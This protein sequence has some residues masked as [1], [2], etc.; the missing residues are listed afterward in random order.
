MLS[1]KEKVAYGLGDAASNIVFQTVML[2]LAVYYT[3][4]VGL[5]AGVVGT[6]FLGVRIFDAVTDPIMGMVADRTTTRWGKFRPFL[7][8]LAVPYGAAT[9]LAFTSFDLSPD[10]KA[11][12][13]AGT[14][15][16]LMTVYT[17]I[18]IPYS[19]LGGVMTADPRERVTVQ[20]YRFAMAWAGGLLVAVLMVPLCEQLGEGNAAR[21]YQRSMLA[22]SVIAA[23]MFLLCFAGTRE[24]VKPEESSGK[25]VFDDLKAL[26]DNDQLLVL[27]VTQVV[28]LIGIASRGTSTVYFANHTLGLNGQAAQVTAFVTTGM[29]GNVV[30]GL[31]S[32]YIEKRI[33]KVVAA[34]VCQLLAAACAIGSL[35]VRPEHVTMH[36]VLHF[37]WAVCIATTV[38]MV[39]AM[40]TDTIDYGVKRTHRRMTGLTFAIN[41]LAIKMGFALGGAMVGWLLAAYGY[42]G[43]SSAQTAAAV[44]GIGLAF[45]A[46][47]AVAAITAAFTLR[48]Y[49]LDDG[50]VRRITKELH[51]GV[52]P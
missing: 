2:F 35:F 20:S 11:L 33:E 31:G 25:S 36:F 19:A 27:C 17:A 9:V 1:T 32:R 38:P 48:F 22:L 44:G 28:L 21:G 39:W 6:I 4:V 26:K 37:G 15:A 24:R 12:V 46:M 30:G 23:V 52:A 41:L 40:V 16:L 51:A 47:S 50:A 45:G 13:A 43:N 34:P 7:L 49:R 3:D 42:Q 10:G 5:P 29:V 14:Y 18:N 8:W